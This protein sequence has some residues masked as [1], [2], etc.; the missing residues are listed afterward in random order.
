MAVTG[1]Q[2]VRLAKVIRETGSNMVHARNWGT[3]TDTVLA[4]R[5]VSDAKPVLGF[6]G[7]QNRGGFN[8]R[9]RV[10]ACLL[11]MNKHVFTAVSEASGRFLVENVNCKPENV[12]VLPNGVDSMRFTLSRD[13]RSKARD[14]YGLGDDDYVIGN[15][16]NF[17]SAVKGHK[18]LVKAF[19]LVAPE[20]TKAKLLLVGFGPLQKDILELVRFYELEAS[21]VF[22][23][24]V[25]DVSEVLPAM[26]V[27]VCPSDSEGMSN[28]VLEAMACSLPL[29]GNRCVGSSSDVFRE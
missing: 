4:C 16:G 2:F 10:R 7:L 20:I 24:G 8:W 11:R 9:Q 28:A 26:D 14:R 6:H 3:W 1:G 23:D 21:V 29:C 17:F 25:E 27:Y 22:A 13:N 15:V 12:H 19:A 18:T 5:M